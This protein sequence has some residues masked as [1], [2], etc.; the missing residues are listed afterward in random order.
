M[1]SPRLTES[2]CTLGATVPLLNG[3]HPTK[4]ILFVSTAVGDSWNWI[5]FLPVE[6]AGFH[7]WLEPLEQLLKGLLMLPPFDIVY[8]LQLPLP[9]LCAQVSPPDITEEKEHETQ[10]GYRQNYT[11]TVCSP[12]QIPPS[13]FFQVSFI[14]EF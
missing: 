1:S 2:V 8:Y 10:M 14:N 3:L 4:G 5:G 13:I 6:V 7:S 9:Q 12:F 11:F